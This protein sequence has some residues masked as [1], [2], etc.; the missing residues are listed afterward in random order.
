LN[1]QRVLIDEQGRSKARRVPVN[2]NKLFR[3]VDDITIALEVEKAMDVTVLAAKGK[4]IAPNQDKQG[5]SAS[6]SKL[7]TME[8]MMYTF[9][10]YKDLNTSIVVNDND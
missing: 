7:G 1:A 6:S 10:M 8:S 4:K 9:S 3:D 5:V 2:P